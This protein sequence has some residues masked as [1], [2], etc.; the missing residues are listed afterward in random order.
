MTREKRLTIIVGIFAV[1]AIAAVFSHSGT[2][3]WIRKMRK[4]G[5]WRLFYSDSSVV[6][7][8]AGNAGRCTSHGRLIGGLCCAPTQGPVAANAWI[9]KAMAAVAQDWPTLVP[10]AG[11]AAGIGLAA[12]VAPAPAAAF[13]VI[14]APA[15]QPVAC[16]ASITSGGY[17]NI[18]G[19][20]VV[21]SSGAYAGTY[22]F[23]KGHYDWLSSSGSSWA[24]PG[25][26]APT[27]YA[28]YY[29][30]TVSCGGKYWSMPTTALISINGSGT[31][32]NATIN[33][34]T[35]SVP[36][37]NTNG[38]F[39]GTFKGTVTIGGDSGTFSMDVKWGSAHY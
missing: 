30:G 17:E 7:D 8:G 2:I 20:Q 39:S 36:N 6:Q 12:G 11:L 1:T 33:S 34:V 38:S 32:H 23:I 9:G 16:P 37:Y 24:P 35:Q 15:P 28:V 22:P 4:R 14:C 31:Y 26:G 10:N 27:G 3:F 29:G 21:I 19:G 5:Y 13:S 18:V 25:A